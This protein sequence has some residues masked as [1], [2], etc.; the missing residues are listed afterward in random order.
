MKHGSPCHPRQSGLSLIEL[1]IALTI[2]F[3]VVAVVGYMYLGSRASFR[4]QDSLSTI[5]ENARYALDMMGQNIRMAG[6]IGCSNLASIPPGNLVDHT[7]LGPINAG[8][9]VYPNG[10]GWAAPAGVVRVAGDVL[11]IYEASGGGVAVLPASTATSTVIGANPFAFKNGDVLLVSNCQF[12][13]IFTATSNPNAIAHAALVPPYNTGA[14]AANVYAFQ[15]ID[16]FVGCP[17]ASWS[18]A[19]CS[20]PVALYQRVNNGQAQAL[21]DNV[22]NLAFRLGVDT[23]GTIPPAGIVGV[24]QTPTTVAAANNWANVLTVQVHLLMV[25]GPPGANSNVTVTNQTYNFNNVSYTAAVSDRRLH[26]E[27]TA[28]VAIR[29]RIP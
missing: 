23:S 14:P 12:A 10:A 17:A 24:Y 18:G 13:D 2:G 1:M 7:A 6:Y 26:Q 27:V 25:G 19:A 11:R 4:S 9:Q 22:E 28:T 5:Q 8:L 20:V 3:M 16:Y 15:R 21:I 29:N